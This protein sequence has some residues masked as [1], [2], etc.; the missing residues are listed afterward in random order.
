MAPEAGGAG[1]SLWGFSVSIISSSSCLLLSF[2]FFFEEIYKI[3]NPVIFLL[4]VA[5]SHLANMF[6]IHI[7]HFPFLH[8]FDLEFGLWDSESS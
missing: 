5:A 8:P 6:K 7:P 2:F 3:S 4:P 1:S